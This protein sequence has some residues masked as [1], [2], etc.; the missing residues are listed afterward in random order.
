MGV[1]AWLALGTFAGLAVLAT[2]NLPAIWRDGKAAER[3]PT[4]WIRGLPTAIVVGWLMV[5]GVP[6]AVLGPREHGVTRHVVLDL[7]GLVLALIVLAALV[8]VTAAGLGRPGFVVPPRL[9]RERERTSRAQSRM[10]LRTA[11]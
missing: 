5:L 10:C 3:W 1:G 4:W 6:L 7:S 8:W 9:R 11:E 2:R